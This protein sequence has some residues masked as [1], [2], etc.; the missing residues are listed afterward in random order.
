MNN[1]W[2]YFVSFTYTINL[3]IGRLRFHTYST[4]VK[5]YEYKLNKKLF[6]NYFIL[7]AKAVDKL[8]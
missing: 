7:I 2:I 1:I 5:I 3:S 8:L 4:A 6:L